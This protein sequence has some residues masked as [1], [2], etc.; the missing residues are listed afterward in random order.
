MS[1][2]GFICR[3]HI[4]IMKPQKDNSGDIIEDREL[5]EKNQRQEV[6]LKKGDMVL[7]RRITSKSL[8]QAMK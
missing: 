5:E 6:Q 2:D 1:P 4:K 3:S 7:G 8:Q